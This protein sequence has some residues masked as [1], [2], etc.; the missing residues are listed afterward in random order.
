VT[1]HASATTRFG[2]L[3]FTRSLCLGARQRDR[4]DLADVI[5]LDGAVTLLP[6]AG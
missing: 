1:I 5:D 2:G 4:L 3:S 6:A